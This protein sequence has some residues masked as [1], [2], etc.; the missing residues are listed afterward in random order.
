[1]NESPPKPKE[2]HG[3]DGE[4]VKGPLSLPD[5]EDVLDGTNPMLVPFSREGWKITSSLGEGLAVAG[6]IGFA[7]MLLGGLNVIDHPLWICLLLPA[8]FLLK[9]KRQSPK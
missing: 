7:L 3:A 1:M 8:A 5:F 4:R 6:C 2:P 9:K